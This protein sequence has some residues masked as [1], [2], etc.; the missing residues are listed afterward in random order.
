MRGRIT[1][2][3]LRGW[4]DDYLV[5]DAE[6][7]QAIVSQGMAVSKNGQPWDNRDE[8]GLT[9][10]DDGEWYTVVLVWIPVEP[11]GWRVEHRVLPGLSYDEDVDKTPL[12]QVCSVNGELRIEDRRQFLMW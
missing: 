7:G 3:V 11:N 10:P 1:S 4:A 9:I 8:L 6:T 12:A 2:G 5:H